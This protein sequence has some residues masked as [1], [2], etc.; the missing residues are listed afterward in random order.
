MNN[1]K[2]NIAENKL[3]IG[4]IAPGK[5]IELLRVN[6]DEATDLAI[7]LLTQAQVLRTAIQ[8]RQDQQRQAETKEATANTSTGP[9]S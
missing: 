7:G 5:A 4:K 9:N 1:I 8:L 6:C 2:I 3:V